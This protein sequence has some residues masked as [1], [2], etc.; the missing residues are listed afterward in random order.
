MSV[1]FHPVPEKSSKIL[2][3]LARR[4]NKPNRRQTDRESE[5]RN[6]KEGRRD[7]CKIRVHISL[8]ATNIGKAGI[9]TKADAKHEIACRRLNHLL[10]VYKHYLLMLQLSTSVARTCHGI[11]IRKFFASIGIWDL[12]GSANKSFTIHV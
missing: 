10:T 7:W 12:M 4:A 8:F 1:L 3:D 5:P 9:S 6:S 2:D 11:T